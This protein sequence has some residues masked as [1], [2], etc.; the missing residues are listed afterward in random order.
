MTRLFLDRNPSILVLALAQLDLEGD[1]DPDA[2]DRQM[3]GIY[4]ED[5]DA[6]DLEKPT[7]ED[8]IDITDIAPPE[9]DTNKKKRKDKKK[10]R[11]EGEEEDGVDVDAMDVDVLE[12]ESSKGKKRKL[13]DEDLDELY[14]LDFNSMV[15]DMP[16]RFKY[17]PVLPQAYGLS[18]EE[19]LLADDKDL[20]EYVGLRRV[21][22]PY[23]KDKG[24]TWDAQRAD[25]LKE[26]RKKLGERNG[27]ADDEKARVGTSDTKKRKGKKERQREKLITASTDTA[28]TGDEGDISHTEGVDHN[29]NADEARPSKKRKRKHKKSSGIKEAD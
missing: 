12:A 14:A 25:K 10:R 2:H 8:D 17:T 29:A 4:G 28:Q 13:A 1:W 22:A 24:R 16:T 23:R 6:G 11:N 9:P 5:D 3:A 15:G 20:N 7:W 21:A 26:L 27:D 18:A 19:L